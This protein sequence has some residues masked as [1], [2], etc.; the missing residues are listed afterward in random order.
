MAYQS[1]MRAFFGC[2]IGAVLGSSAFAAGPGLPKSELRL[3]DG[4]SMGSTRLAGVEIRMEPHVKTYWRT[5]GD[6]GLTPVFNWGGS[7][8][9][10][11][12]DVLWPL[13]TQIPDPAGLIFGYE[14]HVIFP[15]LVT[16][17]DPA[18]P[19]HLVLSLDYAVCGT[20]CVPMQGQARADLAP[21][22]SG[23]MDQAQIKAFLDR[24]PRKA[25]VNDGQKPSLAEIAP[26]PNQRA[27]LIITSTAP[28]TQLFVEGPNDYAFGDA[29]PLSETQWRI[30]LVAK[31]SGATLSRLPLMVTL[32]GPDGATETAVTLDDAGAIR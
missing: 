7:D 32:S 18:K 1:M 3:I 27:T 29:A 17:K 15:L 11:H 9:L 2:L 21:S 4:G 22:S 25:A 30:T 12:I 19:V 31:P 8:N 20:L 23:G 5:P 6:S 14:E 24:V 28:V 10:A 26:D 13:P 16:P